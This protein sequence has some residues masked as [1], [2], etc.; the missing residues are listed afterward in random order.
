MKKIYFLLYLGIQDTL[1]DDLTDEEDDGFIDLEGIA[2]PN[3]WVFFIAESY[4]VD[5]SC[6]KWM[7]YPIEIKVFQYLSKKTSH[8][9]LRSWQ[10]NIFNFL[11]TL[12]TL[13]IMS[14]RTK[15]LA[16]KRGW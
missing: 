13:C 10:N 11:D 8:A 3:E 6:T 2:V 7:D 5:T 1:A 12:Y 9:I 14:L 4:T 15:K 16:W